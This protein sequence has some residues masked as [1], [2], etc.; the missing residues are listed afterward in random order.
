MSGVFL[1]LTLEQ[2]KSIRKLLACDIAGGKRLCERARGV[3]QLYV[4]AILEAEIATCEPLLVEVER[5]INQIE[6]GF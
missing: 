3:S 1:N 5:V 2:L 4:V 6:G